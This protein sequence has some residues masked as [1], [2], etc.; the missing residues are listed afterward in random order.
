MGIY[1]ENHEQIENEVLQKVVN[2][3]V[4]H[5]INDKDAKKR[6][7]ALGEYSKDRRI[8]DDELVSRIYFDTWN[9]LRRQ[10]VP[11]DSIGDL[12]NMGKTNKKFPIYNND[13][14]HWIG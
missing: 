8:K 13:N 1:Q 2:M 5:R 12:F 9:E 3:P 6:M 4:E 14:P 11:D 7:Y 10:N